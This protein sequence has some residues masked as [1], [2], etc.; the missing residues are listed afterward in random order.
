FSIRELRM[1]K[2]ASAPCSNGNRWS[3]S[4]PAWRSAESWSSAIQAMSSACRP[5]TAIKRLSSSVRSASVLQEC[6]RTLARTARASA[7]ADRRLFAHIEKTFLWDQCN[8]LGKRADAAIRA[9]RDRAQR[10]T[11]SDKKR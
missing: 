9:R 4:K 5:S 11:E 7:G 8:L 6:D 2:R 1:G 10:V 3:K